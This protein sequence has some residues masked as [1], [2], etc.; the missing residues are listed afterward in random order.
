MLNGS[1]Q[2]SKLW[3]LIY[4][5]CQ[6]SFRFVKYLKPII[7][8]M[9]I[10]RYPSHVCIGCG[11]QI[12][13][14]GMCSVSN[15]CRRSSPWVS[16]HGIVTGCDETPVRLPRASDFLCGASRSPWQL[17]HRTSKVD[18]ETIKMYYDI[19]SLLEDDCLLS[20]TV[21][22]KRHTDERNPGK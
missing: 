6:V 9:A 18:P 20:V 19:S 7:F 22:E 8:R 15:Y 5:G 4:I 21:R 10:L 13:R 12:S 2:F 16:Y 11:K 3:I 17:A 14:N 1:E